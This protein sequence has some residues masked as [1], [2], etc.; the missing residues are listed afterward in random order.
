MN[1]K[2]QKLKTTCTNKEYKIARYWEW[3]GG[4]CY[5]CLRRMG[6]GTKSRKWRTLTCESWNIE[7]N[8]DRSWK[9]FRKY[10]WKGN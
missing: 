1:K 7:R 8:Y 4:L 9:C 6:A 3:A 10:Q 5:I 2:K